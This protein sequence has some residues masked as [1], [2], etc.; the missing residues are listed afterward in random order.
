LNIIAKN[1]TKTENKIKLKNLK[2]KKKKKKKKKKEKKNQKMA[3]PPLKNKRGWLDNPKHLG[4]LR[5]GFFI[6]FYF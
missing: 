5:C 4:W 1:K 2:L 3:K 6:L